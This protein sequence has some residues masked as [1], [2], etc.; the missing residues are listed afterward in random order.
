MK[1]EREMGFEFNKILLMVHK[2]IF[3]RNNFAHHFVR[4]L[5]ILLHFYYIRNGVQYQIL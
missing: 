5:N 4:G 1:Y 2:H 3:H